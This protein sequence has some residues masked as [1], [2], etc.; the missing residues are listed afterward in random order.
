[1]NEVKNELRQCLAQVSSQDTWL[2]DHPASFEF[3]GGQW[4]PN[5]LEQDHPFAKLVSSHYQELVNKPIT[6]E[7][8]PWGTDA[9]L[10]GKVG[11]IPALVIGPGETR[12]AHYPN[13]FIDLSTMILASKLFA[14]TILDWCEVSSN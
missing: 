6:I 9:G 3:F 11:G 12:V 8:S 5:G 4:V 7:A 14:R 13:E 2:K 10:L 1:M